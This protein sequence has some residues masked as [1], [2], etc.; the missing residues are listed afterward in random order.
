M[1]NFS[2]DLMKPE[3]T[4]HRK[5]RGTIVSIHIRKDTIFK[6]GIGVHKWVHMTKW[7]ENY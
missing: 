5:M 3:E 7:I 4:S 2:Q 1:P 6:K